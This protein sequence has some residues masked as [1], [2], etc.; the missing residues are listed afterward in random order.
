MLQYL[1]IRQPKVGKCH[2]VKREPKKLLVFEHNAGL[3]H[4]YIMQQTYTHTHT[5][6]EIGMCNASSR[7]LSR[8][9][10]IQNWTMTLLRDGT[11]EGGYDSIGGATYVRRIPL[12][13]TWTAMY[14]TLTYVLALATYVAVYIPRCSSST[15]SISTSICHMCVCRLL[16]C[17]PH[18]R[19][20][21]RV[22]S[23]LW[24]TS[25]KES[26]VHATAPPPFPILFSSSTTWVALTLPTFSLFLL[27]SLLL[28][29]LLLSPHS[30]PLLL[31]S[32]FSTSSSLIPLLHLIKIPVSLSV[33]LFLCHILSSSASSS[34]EATLIN[35]SPSP[36]GL[37]VSNLYKNLLLHTQ[38]PAFF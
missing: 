16:H 21:S 23:E 6:T 27:S 18:S 24:N 9:N 32:S 17:K 11:E 28:P 1:C 30:P 31:P 36:W 34:T 7:F 2:S 14:A 26:C 20:I 5:H 19:V 4:A 38:L 37:P 13:R 22:A 10:R 8:W 12:L 25:A 29:L 15:R 35:I 3:Q 33:P